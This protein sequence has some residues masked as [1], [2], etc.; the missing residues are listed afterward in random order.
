MTGPA[1]ALLEASGTVLPTASRRRSGIGFAF[2]PLGFP[3]LYGTLDEAF[4]GTQ[5][6]P[7]V[8]SDEGY[9]HPV[10]IGSTSPSNPVD[11]VLGVRGEVKI[12]DVSD[13]VYVDS[14]GGDVGSD[15]Y[16]DFAILKVLQGPGSLVLATVGVNGARG[17]LGPTELL[18][19]PVRSVFG[20]CKDENGVHFI[21]LQKV[22]EQ[23]DLLG[24]GNLVNVLLDSIRRVRAAANLNGL[25][26]VLELMGELLDFA[27]KS[28]RE[29]K[30]LPVFLREVLD[31]ASDIRKEAHVEHPVSFV[32]Y[33]KLETGKVRASLIHQIHK[34]P[35]GGDH[36]IYPIAQ[37]LFLRAFPHPAIDGGHPQRDV[38]GVCLDVI[39]DL[40]DE[41]ASWRNNQSAGLALTPTFA[42]QALEGCQHGKR[43]GGS[44][45]GTRLGDS[46]HVV[47]L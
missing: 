17:D 27:G 18:G 7:V 10:H 4:E 8:S 9:R 23:I 6:V 13:A 38:L 16:P 5:G 33:E 14:T 19:H 45:A 36:E 11:V 43:E 44:L 46:D 26:L 31:N 28:G 3:N 25:W 24:L 20:S 32:K 21:V 30:G 12:D 35:R 41:F 47:P 29:K 22:L 37:S 34:T 2:K 39:M 15:Q 40:D 1:L 42:L